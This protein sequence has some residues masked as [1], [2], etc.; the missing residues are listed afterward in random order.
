VFAPKKVFVLDPPDR[1]EARLAYQEQLGPL[2]TYSSGNY[3]MMSLVNIED[4]G[5]VPIGRHRIFRGVT[6]D[7]VLEVA[8]PHFIVDKVARDPAAIAAALDQT[9][10]HQPTFV[11]A[12][13]D[14]AF[15]LTLSP[16]V[17][18]ARQGVPVHRAL[19]KLDPV[20]LDAMVLARLPA[21]QVSTD[22]S[23]T[24][25]L[26]AG[27]DLAVLVRPLPIDQLIHVTDL[28]QL[29]PAG[30]T[31]F[32]PPVLPLVANVIERDEDLV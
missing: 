5:L 15:K 21:A 28:G 32:G 31:A 6:K 14:E 19:Q 27:A 1:Y 4:P 25:A 7:A 2:A 23:L 24:A 11:A 26:D 10:G 3:T 13:A 20:V 9:F 17:A 18:P 16:D 29:L 12:F 8:K 30:S 22:T